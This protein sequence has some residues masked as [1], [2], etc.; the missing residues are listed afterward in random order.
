MSS[1]DF[2]KIILYFGVI[3]LFIL[4]LVFSIL[5]PKFTGDKNKSVL[6]D[7]YFENVKIMD[8][9]KSNLNWKA[10]AEVA[11]INKDKKVILLNSFTSNIYFDNKLGLVLKGP[12]ADINYQKPSMKIFKPIAKIKSGEETFDLNADQL[13]WEKE[14]NLIEAKGNINIKNKKI[15]LKANESEIDLTHKRITLKNRCQV[16]IRSK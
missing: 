12:Q 8:F 7:F 16:N 9:T 4:I 10:N 1:T 13:I 6:Y 3:L 14:T 11:K 5:T 15:A 2:K